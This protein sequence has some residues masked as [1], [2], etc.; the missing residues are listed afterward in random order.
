MTEPLDPGEEPLLVLNGVIYV[1]DPEQA[2]PIP[3]VND[4]WW[5]A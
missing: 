2:D 1:E 5:Q 4:G 3:W